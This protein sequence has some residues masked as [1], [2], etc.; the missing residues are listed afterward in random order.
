MLASVYSLNPKLDSVKS[1]DS[2]K[3]RMSRPPKETPIV[4]GV[5]L[6]SVAG[7][8]DSVVDGDGRVAVD[9]AA[10]VAVVLFPSV[11]PLPFLLNASASGLRERRTREYRPGSAMMRLSRRN[12]LELL[13]V[14]IIS[15]RGVVRRDLE[16]QAN[17][18]SPFLCIP[19]FQP[20]GKKGMFQ[21]WITAPLPKAMFPQKRL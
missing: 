1:S 11:R 20:Q 15:T 6:L 10:T 13:R 17:P 2:N 7:G 14:W 19:F 21:A 18:V 3:L 9:A 5:L 16:C 4:L 8:G 12:S